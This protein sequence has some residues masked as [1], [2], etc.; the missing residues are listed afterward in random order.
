MFFLGSTVEMNNLEVKLQPD[1]EHLS[2]QR[3]ILTAFAEFRSAV[4]LLSFVHSFIY[5]VLT[6]TSIIDVLFCARNDA[7]H[8]GHL[9]DNQP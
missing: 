9:G 5:L 4:N 6:S 7:K 3:R 8:W 1:N 2:F